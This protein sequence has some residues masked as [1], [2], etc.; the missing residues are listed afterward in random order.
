MYS[1]TILSSVHVSHLYQSAILAEE[2]CD[3]GGADLSRV[4]TN[5]RTIEQHLETRMDE[6]AKDE[7]PKDDTNP[8]PHDAKEL[9]AVE[10][11]TFE[12]EGYEEE[13][14][15]DVWLNPFAKYGTS[16]AST[17][18]PPPLQDSWHACAPTNAVPDKKDPDEALEAIE[19]EDLEKVIELFKK[20]DDLLRWREGTFTCGCVVGFE[21]HE[22]ALHV[23]FGTR[24]VEILK[25]LFAV[26]PERFMQLMG[27]ANTDDDECNQGEGHT[28]PLLYALSLP[29]MRG[30]W[31]TDDH[32]EARKADRAAKLPA[33]IEWMC[34]SGVMTPTLAET[35]FPIVPPQPPR[36]P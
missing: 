8:A 22:N 3:V 18:Q 9:E 27:M 11:H 12:L 32:A 17:L 24:N 26:S 21:Y 20:P 23:A 7:V 14:W 10:E 30:I 19:S 5:L 6:A 15:R 36:H 25:H 31:A 33:V 28:L 13:P 4:A 1:Q 16:H 35:C 34:D 29:L 2:T